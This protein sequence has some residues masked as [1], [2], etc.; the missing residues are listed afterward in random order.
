VKEDI[1][2]CILIVDDDPDDC[3]FL[4]ECLIEA[5]ITFPVKVALMVPQP[6]NSWRV[7]RTIYRS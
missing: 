1:Q 7:G 2:Q 4:M 3:E 5:G 6:L